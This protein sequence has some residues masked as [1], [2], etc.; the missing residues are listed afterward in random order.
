MSP[1]P[2]PGIL[3]IAPYVGGRATIPGVA[4]A[5]KLSSNESPLGPSPAAMEALRA[6][7]FGR[8]QPVT[9]AVLGPM[10]SFIAAFHLGDPIGPEDSF[11][12][13]LRRRRIA[14]EAAAVRDGTGSPPS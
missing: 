8:L 12:L 1:T 7:G 3:D 13:G 10:A 6:M 14:A 2:K 5:I 9:P 11:H 4:K